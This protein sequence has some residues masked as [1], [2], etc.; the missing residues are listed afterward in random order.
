[1]AG[2]DTTQAAGISEKP[3]LAAGG[4]GKGEAQ[5]DPQAL[6]MPLAVW[7]EYANE[8]TSLPIIA[9]RHL[10]AH[11]SAARQT[12]GEQLRLAS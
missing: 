12:S 6:F 3:T 1:M 4:S 7:C 10:L 8:E 5:E 9:G 11:A 2:E